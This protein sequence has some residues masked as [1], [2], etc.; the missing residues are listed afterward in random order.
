M[1][2]ALDL[3]VQRL[4]EHNCSPTEHGTATCPAH[5]DKRASLTFKAG[6][7]GVVLH[8]HAGC[9]QAAVVEALG[10]KM[11]DLF[12]DASGNGKRREVASYDYTDETGKLLFQVV[13][14]EPKDFRQRKPDGH[15][16]WDWKLGDTRRVLY[17]LPAAIKAVKAGRV[18]YIPEGEKDVATLVSWDLDAT[19][20]PG[21]A[22]KWKPEYSEVLRNAHV[23]IIPDADRPGREHAAA[24]AASLAGVAAD[25]RVVEL[26][27][28]KDVTAWRDSHGGTREKLQALVTHPPEP[29]QVEIGTA[30]TTYLLTDGGNAERF[31]RDHAGKVRYCGAWGRFLRWDDTRW[32]ANDDG[33][34]ER[35]AKATVRAMIAEAV[36]L[37][38]DNPNRKRAVLW[39]VQSD[40]RARRDALLDLA[41][42]E[43]GVSVRP[44]ELD[45]QPYLLNVTN[46][47]IDLR[48]GHLLPH[49][50]DLLLTKLAQVEYRP[51]AKAPLFDAYLE[52]VLPD[53]QVRRFMQRFLGYCL[54]AYVSEQVLLFL[55]G[56]GA[57]GK[58]TLVNI[59]MF[60]LG[61]YARQAAPDLLMQRTGDHHPTELADLL[62]ARFV[63]TV[64]VQEGRR[65]AEVLVKQLSGGDRLKARYMRQDFWEFEPTHKLVL[66]ANHKPVV[67]GTDYAIW[68]RI[69]MVPFNV[70]IPPD[71]RD[72]RLPEKLKA[73][74]PGI[75]R[76]L[77]EGCLAWQ[78]DG[79]RPPASVVAATGAYQHEMDAL[80]GWIDEHC[81]ESFDAWAWS[82]DLY[83]DYMKW[84]ET[85][86]ERHLRRV[87]FGTRLTE[88]GFTATKG[89]KGRRRWLGIGL[90]DRSGGTGGA[91][92]GL[93]GI[94]TTRELSLSAIPESTPPMPPTPPREPGDDD[95]F[96][97]REAL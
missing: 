10:L 78:R 84:C 37:P 21:G 57:N 23:V 70:T 95:E 61:G 5:D 11:G 22:S 12:D 40:S 32:Q 19:C 31:A 80:G 48:D 38:D 29:A 75:L 81:I 35:M 67:R 7:K 74:A 26:P 90:V 45:V 72:P 2:A 49:N 50:P 4:K 83:A 39:A 91:G 92:G 59:I 44:A 27:V 13:R 64:E 73:E 76:W 85:A 28:G 1:S 66:V 3:V 60:T 6:D 42:S 36:N 16:G 18:V 55:W 8:C 56:V 25:V 77:V 15:G 9:S 97:P 89:L 87:D 71:E 34:V 53:E 51:D 20:N 30:T 54:T 58:T 17:R 47:V 43:P 86:G 63:P 62:G 88:R 33:A 96:I 68:R 24:V 82:D 46:G 93:F 14:F 69:L 41:K 79:L 65:L 94:T 52:R